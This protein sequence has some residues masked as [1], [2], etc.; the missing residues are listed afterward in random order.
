MSKHHDDVSV[1]IQHAQEQTQN[2]ANG[3]RPTE[4]VLFEETP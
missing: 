2:H 3:V 1:T 4:K